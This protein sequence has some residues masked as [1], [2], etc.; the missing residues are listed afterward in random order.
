MD[1]MRRAPS[2]NVQDIGLKLETILH[3]RY[4]ITGYLSMGQTSLIYLAYD[5]DSQKE[6]VV[7]EFCP[8]AYANRD[9]DQLTVI[10]KGD[11]YT[12]QFHQMKEAF[13]QECAILKQLTQRRDRGSEHIVPYLDSFS[14]NETVYLVMDYIKGNDLEDA[15]VTGGKLSFKKTIRQILKMVECIHKAGILHL[16]LKP[17]NILINEKQELMLIDF[18]SA[19]F[20]DQEVN[21]VS[22]ATKGYSAPEL[23]TNQ[24]VSRA[25]DVYSVGAMIYYFA[26]GHV[27][28]SAMERLREDDLRA[29]SSYVKIPGMMEHYVMK[30]LRLQA[31]ERPKSLKMLYYLFV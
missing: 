12:S 9:L 5:K 29:I 19:R 24:S 21:Q 10:C 3:K 17:S 6:V 31:V 16:D 7:K 20:M 1:D 14:E 4:Q 2:L 26:T 15:L 23:F 13:I 27:P 11:S 18:G 8:Y 22:F 28:V 25:T 30:C